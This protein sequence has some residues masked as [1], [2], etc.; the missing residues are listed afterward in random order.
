[1]L[2]YLIFVGYISLSLCGAAV[3]QRP[4]AGPGP[5]PSLAVSDTLTLGSTTLTLGDTTTAVTGLASLS[6]TAPVVNTTPL[7][8]SGY[9]LTGSDASPLLDLS[10]TWNTTGTPTG[11]KLNVTDTASN[12]ASLL[13]DLQVGGAGKFTVTKAGTIKLVEG[14]TAVPSI[15]DMDETNSG[16]NFRFPGYFT[17]NG[18]GIPAIDVGT[19]GSEKFIRFISDGSLQWNSSAVTA[20]SVGDLM[21]W[22]DAAGILAQRN[23]TNAQSFR[24]YDTYTDAINYERA[25]FGFTDTANVLTIGTQN[26]GSGLAQNIDVVIG[27]VRKL[28]Y[29]ITNAGYWSFSD[30]ITTLASLESTAT[31]GIV[32]R[33][34]LGAVLWNGYGV[35]KARADGVFSFTNDAGTDFGRL[36]LGGTTSS[37]PALKRSTTTLQVRLAD[38]SD[39]GGF[40]ASAYSVGATAGAS[41][42]PLTAVTSLT[43]VNGIVT[44][45]GGT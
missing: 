36:Q 25:V 31:N 18:A 19:K 3:A 2:R 5:S 4:P 32:L 28:D 38:D 12:A 39:Y 10:G 8:I 13:M 45:C 26:S 33:G 34:S 37:F 35:L 17:F 27:G 6:I 23:S 42:G 1:M 30:A 7:T 22:R 20:V 24:V 40:A 14:T 29:G 41:C 21:L 44:A 15:A 9:S 16:I 43:V 11:L